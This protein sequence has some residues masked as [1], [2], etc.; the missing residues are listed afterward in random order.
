MKFKRVFLIVLD[1]LGVGAMPDAAKFNDVGANTLESI[2]KA[3]DIVNIPNLQK[4]GFTNLSSI[5]KYHTNNPK[6]VV[7]KLAEESNGKDT[8]TGHWEFMGIKTVEP[9][10]TFTEHGFPK[11]LI[12]E[13]EEKTGYKVIGNKAASG[14]EILDELGPRQMKTKE[15][16]VYTSADSVLQIAAHEDII[17]LK[18]LYRCCEIAR[19]IT[20][21]PE[22]L[23]GRV[24][25]RPYIGTP[26]NFKRTP[27]R[28]DYALKPP[29]DT[30]LDNLKN[31]GY[32]TISIGK[33]YDIF[34]GKGLTE[35]NK[36]ISNDD[37][38][39]QTIAMVKNRDFKGLCFVNLVDFDA[40]YGHR[41]NAKGYATALEEFDVKLNEV[42][43]NLKDDDLL[44]LTADHGNDP[45]FRGSDHTREYAPFVAYYNKL[46]KGKMLPVIESFASIGA[47]IAEN[48]EVALPKIGE[49]INI[50]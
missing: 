42:L 1:S 16:I 37:G 21:K 27:N 6:A 50:D 31:S 48:F 35:S 39:D 9:F 25:A 10:V 26:N 34:D 2:L 33:I 18:E 15:L 45:N 14:T 38:M 8:M 40:V 19:A 47:T 46:Q 30:V 36:T 23:L 44:I 20:M 28:H 5:N 24:I 4:L 22:W 41:R 43:T 3:K 32:E 17:P 29:K 13:L 12:D 7:A 11:E 49:V